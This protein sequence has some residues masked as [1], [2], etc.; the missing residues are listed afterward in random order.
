M[1]K[2]KRAKDIKVGVIGYGG[3][4]SM[5]RAHINEM[6][7]AGMTAVAVAETDKSRL[8]VAKE[9]F[10]GIETYT[11]AATMLRKSDVNLIT[12]ITPHNTHAKLALQCLDA[13]RHVVCE[14]PLAITTAECDAM[15]D[16][17][18]QN[19]VVI[20]T[21]HNRHWDGCILHAVKMIVK[22]KVIG[23]VVR[24]EAHGGGYGKPGPWWRSSKSISGG[25]LYDW[26]VHFLEYALQLIDS[27]I[28]EVM[29]LAKTGVWA[30]KTA[31]KDDTNEDDAFAIVRFKSGQWLTLHMSQIDSM[32]K[33]DRG[34]LE[35]TGTRGTY[36]MSGGDYKL[37]RQTPK[38]PKEET[39]PIPPGEGWRFYQNVSDHLVKGAKLVIT[40]E[41]ARRPIHILDLANR[42]VKLGKAIE[43]KYK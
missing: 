40:G 20:S 39:G 29:G 3:A 9:D 27:D 10:P 25:I 41:W 37:I 7:K 30:P 14:K 18:K 24:V 21:Y 4:F 34:M 19:K 23:D 1:K 11:S 38:G 5:G 17:A 8:E 31:W 2:F 12:I 15:I 35:I 22:R 43:A 42:S 28:V 33:H 13:G 32:P 36:I 6:Q 16:A 26:G